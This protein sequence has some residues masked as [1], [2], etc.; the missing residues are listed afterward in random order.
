MPSLICR[1]PFHRSFPHP[2]LTF[3]GK[4]N[5]GTN[6]AEILLRLSP[7]ERGRVLGMSH[8]LPQ[9]IAI[10]TTITITIFTIGITTIQFSD[11]LV[12]A[13]IQALTLP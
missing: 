9:T 1:K 8:K 2:R 5:V 12:M 3:I 11:D 10:K 7:G 4:R 6:F 13:L